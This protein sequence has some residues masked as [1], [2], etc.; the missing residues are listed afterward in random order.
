MGARAW[1]NM[2]E[3]RRETQSIRTLAPWDG[4]RG[5]RRGLDRRRA[6]LRDGRQHRDGHD[7]VDEGKVVRR[8]R[9]RLGGSAAHSGVQRHRCQHQCDMI[10][11]AQA[12]VRLCTTI[13]NKAMNDGGAGECA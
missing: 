6:S 11:E 7:G 3:G 5:A 12:R 13:A 1:T 8:R 10:H 9:R 2:A 4:G